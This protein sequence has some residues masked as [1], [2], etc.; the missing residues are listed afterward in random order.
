MLLGG[1]ASLKHELSDN[2]YKASRDVYV[3]VKASGTVG[4][5]QLRLSSLERMAGVSG[6]IGSTISRECKNRAPASCD[7][8]Q[9]ALVLLVDGGV[10]SDVHLRDCAR[11]AYRSSKFHRPKRLKRPD[12]VPIKVGQAGTL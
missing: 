5:C 4:R 2:G 7:R 12:A 6:R 9:V 1:T 10:V 11:I 3:I 8:F